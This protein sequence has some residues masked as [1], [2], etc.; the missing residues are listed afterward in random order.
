MPIQNKRLKICYLK[1]VFMLLLLHTGGLLFAQNREW[2]LDK[3]ERLE[4]EKQRELDSLMVQLSEN[5]QL[6][7]SFGQYFFDNSIP[8][9][10]EALLEFPR[11]ASVWN[12]SFSKYL[13]E[14]I[15]INADFGIHLKKI[16]PSR[17]DLSLVLNGQDIE[18][19]GGGVLFVPMSIGMD[20]FLMKQRFRPYLGLSLGRVSGR[21]TY[22]E[23]SGNINV[24][25]NRDEFT[26]KST[27][28]F[29]E[30]STGFI[31]RTAKNTQLGFSC[32]YTR[33]GQFSNVIGT[34][35]EYN[36][37]AISAVLAI[38]F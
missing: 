2:E 6:S 17:P 16:K 35:K 18:I 37:L 11:N 22:V 29:V 27:Q 14:S 5:W 20:Y 38:L 7:L 23:G 30:F 33:S 8:S 10:E 32:D 36:G 4:K 34:Y 13:S 3:I 26:V 25:F 1:I 19:D 21:F 31:Y 9:T 24:G 12:L 28:P 15:A